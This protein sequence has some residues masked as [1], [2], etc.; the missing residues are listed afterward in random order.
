MSESHLP[1]TSLV[2]EMEH[3]RCEC[4]DKLGGTLH[5][6]HGRHGVSCPDCWRCKWEAALARAREQVRNNWI[7]LESERASW[8]L[9]DII[10]PANE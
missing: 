5:P 2:A 3:E 8:V 6:H 1:F 9:R 7:F 10:G 4:A